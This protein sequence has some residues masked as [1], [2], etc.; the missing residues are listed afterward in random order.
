MLIVYL[1]AECVDVVEI[2]KCVTSKKLKCL[3]L[4]STYLSSYFFSFFFCLCLLNVKNKSEVVEPIVDS[5]AGPGIS[6]PLA[7]EKCQ[8]VVQKRTIR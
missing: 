4:F 8:D 7:V 6:H 3:T 1:N 5:H 2:A